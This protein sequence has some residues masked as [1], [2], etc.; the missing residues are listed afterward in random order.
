MQAFQFRCNCESSNPTDKSAATS[1]CCGGSPPD[2]PFETNGTTF[3][4]DQQHKGYMTEGQCVFNM[5]LGGRPFENYETAWSKCCSA[6]RSR[7]SGTCTE[8]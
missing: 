3:P 6:S 4:D 5:N 8:S 1:Q 2:L 7:T